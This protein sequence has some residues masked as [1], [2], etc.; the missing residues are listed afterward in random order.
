MELTAFSS[1]MTALSTN[2]VREVLAYNAPFVLHCYRALLFG[3][4]PGAAQLC[5]Q[6]VLI[7]LLHEFLSKNAVHLVCSS[8]D[9]VCDV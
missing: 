5:G 9:L 2:Q 4:E 8:N 3:V 7:D 6:R 1:T